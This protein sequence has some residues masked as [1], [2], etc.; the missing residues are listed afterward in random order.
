[1][2]RQPDLS[3]VV[4]VRDEEDNL[5]PLTD[6][7]AAALATAPFTWELILVDDGSTD[8]SREVMRDL[9]AERIWVR[10]VVLDRNHGQTAAL[11][12]G[13]RRSAGRYLASM[14]ADLQNDPADFIPLWRRINESDGSVDMVAGVRA[15]RR[16]GIWKRLQSRIGNG[17]RNLITGET[18][19]DTGCSMKMMKRE[20][21]DRVILFQGMHRFLPTLVRM[22]GYQVVEMAVNH[23][24]RRFGQTKYGMWDRAW[25]GLVD[26][27]AI[28]WMKSRHP[29]YRVQE[30]E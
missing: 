26:C 6:E 27:I 4:P 14:D 18:I 2:I 5:R 12:A 9:E 22:Q 29:S 25:R 20:C 30:K 7:V 24:H 21:L 3:I 16:D 23:R 1:M 13:W 8:G 19:T 15:R 10:S 11:D 28:R 17:V